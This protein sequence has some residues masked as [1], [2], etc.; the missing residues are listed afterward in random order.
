VD[1]ENVDTESDLDVDSD[2]VSHCLPKFRL[3][4]SAACTIRQ[5][6]ELKCVVPIYRAQWDIAI[7]KYI[8]EYAATYPI[9][10]LVGWHV[11]RSLRAGQRRRCH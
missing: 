8:R 7:E 4:A 11:R 6:H 10:Q 9:F 5:A 2:L 3:V 1:H